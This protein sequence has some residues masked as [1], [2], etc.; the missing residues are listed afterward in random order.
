MT[1]QGIFTILLSVL[2]VSA[3][4]PVISLIVEI[5]TNKTNA[6]KD[7]KRKIVINKSLSTDSNVEVNT[8]SLSKVKTQVKKATVIQIVIACFNNGVSMD[9]EKVRTVD[10][11]KMGTP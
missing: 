9:D 11:R 5:I 4:V 2:S 1:L 6:K 7:D 3:C 10:Y 8:I